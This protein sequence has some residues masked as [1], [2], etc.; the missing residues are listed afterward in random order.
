[1]IAALLLAIGTF[2]VT[3]PWGEHL[4]AWLRAKGIGKQIRVDGPQG[5]ELKRGTPTMGGIL[6]LVP[7]FLIGGVLAVRTPRLLAPIGVTEIFAMLGAVDDWRGLRDVKGYGWLARY[8]V[9]WQVALGLL[10]AG[11][12][13][14]AGAPRAVNVP[15]LNVSLGL[16]LAYVP[17]AA[18]V[19]VSTINAV[20]VHDGLDGLA[21]GTVAL[22]FAAYGLIALSPAGADAP[23]G[24]LCAVFIGGLLAFLWHNVH[25]AKVFMGD[26]G[27]L[28]LGAGLAS[29]ALMTE[30]WLLLPVIGA[31]YVAEV[32]ADILQVGYFKL[33]HGRRIFRMAPLHCHFEQCG[34]PETRIVF[35]FWIAAAVLAMLGVALAVAR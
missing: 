23:L 14:L 32:V 18:L 13:Y 10:G 3:V 2:L 16:G 20:N 6:F 25:P 35:R 19:I 7:V 33:T 5:H 12:L 22:A 17:L 27:A 26:L 4:I 15:V 30:H 28:A 21:G 24:L 31:V 9:P 29:V 8:K 1:M 34:W 11:A